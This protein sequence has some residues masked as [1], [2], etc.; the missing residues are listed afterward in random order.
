M[1]LQYLGKLKVN[2]LQILGRY[3]RKC[4]QILI[5]SVFEIANFANK[6]INVT[7]FFTYLLLR[8]IYGSR[9]SSQRTSLQCLST[10][11]VVFS[12]EDKILIKS[13]YWK[14]YIAKRLTDEFSEN[15]WTKH[16]VNKLLKK[17]TEPQTLNNNCLFSDP[18]TFTKITSL[19]M[20]NI[21][22]ILLTHK[23]TK[24]TQLQSQRN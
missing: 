11:D 4:K 12:D 15:S 22:N 20:L 3:G 21:L 10:I 24:H 2:Y 18:P 16:G 17:L 8:S 6:I 19:C 5:F 23:Y 7:V 1:L 9:N 13:L 14:R